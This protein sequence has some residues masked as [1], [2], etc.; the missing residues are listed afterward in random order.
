ML[1]RHGLVSDAADVDRR[2]CGDEGSPADA[3]MKKPEARVSYLS[4]P[5]RVADGGVVV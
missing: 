3:A 5:V 1:R 4:T 2:V